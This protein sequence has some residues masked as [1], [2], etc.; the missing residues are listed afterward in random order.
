M[1]TISIKVKPAVFRWINNNYPKK[2]GAYDVR[3]NFLHEMVVCGLVRK[4]N[5]KNANVSKFFHSWK[6]V[7]LIVSGYW[8]QQYGYLLTYENQSKINSALFNLLV[9]E[10]C[11][12]VMN[13]HILT[14]YPKNT[15]MKNYLYNQMYRE[16]ELKLSCISKIYQRKYLKKETYIREIFNKIDNKLTQNSHKTHTKICSKYVLF[17]FNKKKL[18]KISQKTAALPLF[19]D[20]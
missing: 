3:N 10:I 2:N 12:G 16:N 18:W 17:K 1:A 9:N 11:T 6:S 5:N 8:V 20:T 7:E 4:C 15:L 19:P 14:G 13:A